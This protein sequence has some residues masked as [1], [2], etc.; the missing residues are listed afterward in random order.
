MDLEPVC[1]HSEEPRS[2]RLAEVTV[3]TLFNSDR[4]PALGRTGAA[5]TRAFITGPYTFRTL[6]G[7][8]TGSRSRPRTKSPVISAF[9]SRAGWHLP[10]SYE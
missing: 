5:L 9:T 6:H 4:D 7:S 1:V 10:Y 3:P 2:G 8:E